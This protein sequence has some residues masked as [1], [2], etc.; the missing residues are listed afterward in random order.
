MSAKQ[1][2][3]R[4]YNNKRTNG[5]VSKKKIRTRSTY[6]QNLMVSSLSN[7][8]ISASKSVPIYSKW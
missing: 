1:T 2:K 3:T 5:S 7:F 4:S 8:A 6:H